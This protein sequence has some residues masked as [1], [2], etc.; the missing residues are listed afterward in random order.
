MKIYE[1]NPDLSDKEV[2]DGAYWERN[3]LALRF[4]E[5][6]YNDDI[7]KNSEDLNGSPIEITAPRYPE[8]RRVL[9]LNK[10]TITFH[11]P[12]NFDT[13]NLPCI[14]PDWDGHTT[15]EKWKRIMDYREIKE[16]ESEKIELSWDEIKYAVL[17]GINP[18]ARIGD[19][20]VDWN[21]V[22]DKLGFK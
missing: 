9:S 21:I 17:M 11:I 20:V 14:E 16:I 10:G 4:A 5:G 19:Q 22:K 6:W 12:N 18:C 1:W 13:G 15:M 8:W 7:L 3:M 2:S